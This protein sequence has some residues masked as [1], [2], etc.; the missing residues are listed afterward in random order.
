MWRETRDGLCKTE[1]CGLAIG[2]AYIFHCHVKRAYVRTCA[3]NRERGTVKTKIN[4]HS[5]NKTCRPFKDRK[6]LRSV[7]DNRVK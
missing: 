1:F 7:Y 4:T 2:M 3:A 6:W 5:S